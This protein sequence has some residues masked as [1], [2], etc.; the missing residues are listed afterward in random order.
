MRRRYRNAPAL[1]ECAGAI[2]DPVVAARRDELLVAVIEHQEAWAR[3]STQTTAET[4]MVPAH[5]VVA[6]NRI[7]LNAWNFGRHAGQ[8]LSW[9]LP[10][11]SV[12]LTDDRKPYAV[13]P[14][15]NVATS[16]PT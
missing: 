1:P 7:P 4:P 9:K 5:S 6:G 10:A 2:H 14:T 12:Q 15:W 3:Q 13:S 8:P 16:A 11:L